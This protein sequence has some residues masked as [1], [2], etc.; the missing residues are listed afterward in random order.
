MSVKVSVLIPTKNR[1]DNLSCMLES[2]LRQTV[3]ANEVIIVDQSDSFSTRNVV[4]AITE[5]AA[6]MEVKYIHDQNIT[7]ICQARNRAIENASGDIIFFFDDDVILDINYIKNV[8]IVYANYPDALGIGGV[9]TNY[10]QSQINLMTLFQRIFFIGIFNDKRMRIYMNYQR[11]HKPIKSNKLTGCA[12]SFRK[13]V[14]NENLFDETIDHF[15]RGYA[16]GEDIEF[17]LRVSKK[18]QLYIAPSVQLIHNTQRAGR[19]EK[20]RVKFFFQEVANWTYIYNKNFRSSFPATVA[21]VWLVFGWLLRSIKNLLLLDFEMSSQLFSG[22]RKGFNIERKESQA[23]L[24][25]FL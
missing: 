9:M 20:E 23:A 24:N 15:M 1:P 13:E 17:T 2:L 3:Q 22:L 25:K 8:L 12:F 4:N 6:G 19:P 11:F 5:K 18:G 16:L 7:G 14:F 10:D 21:F